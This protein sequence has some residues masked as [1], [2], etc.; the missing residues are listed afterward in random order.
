MVKYI[1]MSEHGPENLDDH[2]A[3]RF[4]LAKEIGRVASSFLVGFAAFGFTGL[5][6]SVPPLVPTAV[7]LASGYLFYKL[8]QKIRPNR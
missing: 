1:T 5:S 7:G 3:R 8:T 2:S 6:E 4:R